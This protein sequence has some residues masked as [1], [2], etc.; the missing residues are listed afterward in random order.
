ME[1]KTLKYALECMCVSSYV[2]VIV[3]AR[4]FEGVRPIGGGTARDMI[5]RYGQLQVTRSFV[6][7]NM[8]YVDV[9]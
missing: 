3:R 9:E 8:L 2:H 4:D 7:D 1:N 5:S 6:V